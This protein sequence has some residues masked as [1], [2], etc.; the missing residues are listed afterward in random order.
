[1]GFEGSRRKEQDQLDWEGEPGGLAL[2]HQELQLHLR[3]LEV[4]A[5]MQCKVGG[6]PTRGQRVTCLDPHLTTALWQTP[7][8]QHVKPNQTGPDEDGMGGH[9]HF[10]WD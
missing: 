3:I 1:M 9:F 6:F 8:C 2:L 10:Y 5:G 4:Q 7:S